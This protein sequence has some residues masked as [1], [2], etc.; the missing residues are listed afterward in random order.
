MSR[1][2]WL[3]PLPPE[4]S[5][6]ADYSAEVLGGLRHRFEIELFCGQPA[7]SPEV[8]GGMPVR[9]YAQFLDEHRLYRTRFLGH[10]FA[11]GGRA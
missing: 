2:A 4:A 7:S 5:G 9:G 8:L 6:I 1:V 10:T 3:S 11:L